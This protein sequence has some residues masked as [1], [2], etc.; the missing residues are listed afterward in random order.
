M[1][2]ASRKSKRRKTLPENPE[3][4]AQ[5][6]LTVAIKEDTNN[7][8]D[9]EANVKIIDNSRHFVCYK[10]IFMGQVCHAAWKANRTTLDDGIKVFTKQQYYR[11][12]DGE[13]HN[14]QIVEIKGCVRDAVL[15]NCAVSCS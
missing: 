6:Y 13:I 14:P 12:F 11:H 15:C 9:Y 10:C 5:R 4:L 1:V 3:K 8:Y 2:Q 7:I